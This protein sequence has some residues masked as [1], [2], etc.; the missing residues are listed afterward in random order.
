MGLILRFKENL[1]NLEIRELVNDE[2]DEVIVII[3]LP[4]GS[5]EEKWEKVASMY[6]LPEEPVDPEPE[7]E[8]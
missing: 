3:G 8:V 7:P 4:T 2:N 1:G 6:F 5:S